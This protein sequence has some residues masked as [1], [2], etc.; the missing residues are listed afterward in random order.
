MG[1]R[2]L[3]LTIIAIASFTGGL[4]ALTHSF[5]IRQSQQPATCTYKTTKFKHYPTGGTNHDYV[6]SIYL[7]GT[8]W[9]QVCTEAA[10]NPLLEA[11]KSRCHEIWGRQGVH[12][13]IRNPHKAVLEEGQCHVSIT[14]RVMRPKEDYGFPI[15]EDD[16]IWDRKPD[17]PSIGLDPENFPW[18][19]MCFNAE[20]GI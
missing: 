14:V 7:P 9:V 17:F 20:V 4:R 15:F 19:S 5:E 18:P 13:F 8:A 2:L 11:V 12:K 3:K 10:M 16:C 6:F 1:S